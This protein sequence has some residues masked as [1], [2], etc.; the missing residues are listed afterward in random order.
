M[1]IIGAREKLR[2]ENLDSLSLDFL[3]TRY[4]SLVEKRPIF[5]SFRT[6]E[7]CREESKE[8]KEEA[9]IPRNQTTGQ[10]SCLKL[11]GGNTVK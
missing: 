5:R 3:V 2:R 6:R 4:F 11:K 8:R 1:Q 10:I 9:Y 7:K